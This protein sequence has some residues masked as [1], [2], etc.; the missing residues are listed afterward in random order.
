MAIIKDINEFLKEKYGIKVPTDLYFNVDTRIKLG[1][2]DALEGIC[3]TYTDK[4]TGAKLFFIA[5]TEYKDGK[6]YCTFHANRGLKDEGI[7][8][9]LH[10]RSWQCNLLEHESKVYLGSNN[11]VVVPMDSGHDEH[12]FIAL[13]HRALPLIKS[14]LKGVDRTYRSNETLGVSMDAAFVLAID[15]AVDKYQK[16]LHKEFNNW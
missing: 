2:G 5:E 16:L 1:Y 14:A 13:F 4:N 15:S 12:K 10:D 6:H 8:R 3:L 9:E 11:S 7:L